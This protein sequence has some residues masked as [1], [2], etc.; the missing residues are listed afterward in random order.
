MLH[1][2]S[3]VSRCIRTILFLSVLLSIPAPARAQIYLK[4]LLGVEQPSATSAAEDS[5]VQLARAQLG[6]RYLWGGERPETGFDCSGLMRHVLRA[7]GVALPRTSAE[8][9]RVGKE[10]PRDLLQLRPGDLL[11][12]GYGSRISHVGVYVGEGRYVHASSVTGR[13]VEDRI[14][15]KW[16]L[17]SMW[18]KGARRVIARHE[19]LPG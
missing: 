2:S 14:P 1:R 18:W 7:V 16:L 8:Q 12:F 11:T 15:P 13:V 19:T 4:R 6:T 17:H 5:I 9:A 3:N 10:I